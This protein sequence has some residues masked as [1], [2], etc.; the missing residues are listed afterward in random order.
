M[1]K[2]EYRRTYRWALYL[3]TALLYIIWL[4]LLFVIK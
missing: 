1:S 3:F 2:E 4:L